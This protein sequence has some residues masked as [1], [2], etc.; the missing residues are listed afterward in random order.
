MRRKFVDG[1]SKKTRQIRYIREK[2]YECPPTVDREVKKRTGFKNRTTLLTYIVVVCNED[3]NRVRKR[4]TVLIWF[5]EWV[6]YFKW[7]CG[8]T[9][10]SEN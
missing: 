7:S 4:C 2:K 1:N 6:L 8:H 9:N 3:F 10:K 5:E